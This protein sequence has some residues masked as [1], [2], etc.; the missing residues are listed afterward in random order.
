ME[1]EIYIIYLKKGGSA[2]LD[3]RTHPGIFEI[4]WYDPR[5]G[6][7]YKLGSLR[8]LTGGS[9]A[10]IGSPPDTPNEDWAVLVKRKE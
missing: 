2:R 7:P 5:N 1:G 10:N 4:S 8:S 3:L 9:W 6:G